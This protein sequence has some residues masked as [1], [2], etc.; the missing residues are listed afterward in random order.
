MTDRYGHLAA[1]ITDIPNRFEIR[2]GPDGNIIAGGLAPTQL[3][4]GMF[5]DIA[6]LFG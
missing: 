1:G 2:I 5:K 4:K 6:A 3:S